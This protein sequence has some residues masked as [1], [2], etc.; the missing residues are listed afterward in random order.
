MK[1]S[2][3]IHN[4]RYPETSE[5]ALARQLQEATQ[6]SVI[7]MRDKTD[8]MKWDAD[9]DEISRA[10]D[11]IENYVI[12]LFLA[13]AFGFSS[14]ARTLYQFNTQQFLLVAMSSGGSDNP[15][16]VAL[17]QTGA[18]EL[19]PWYYEEKKM[20]QS[21]S[22]NSVVKLAREIVSDWSQTVRKIAINEGTRAQVDEETKLRYGVYSSWSKNRASGI[23]G[24]FNSRLMRQRLKDANV[25]EYI[26]RGKMDE[27][28]RATHIALEGKSRKMTQFPFPGE[29]YNCRCW[30]IPNWK[31]RY[32]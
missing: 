21:Q 16:V 5:R 30:A 29:E 22:Q 2:G 13:V 28:E 9:D 31:T 23:V 19:E 3:K 18:M 14:V 7:M 24:S 32:R 26:W 27:R 12:G 10:E 8:R 11:E 4:W 6:K 25:S 17:N 20:W 15:S 1:V